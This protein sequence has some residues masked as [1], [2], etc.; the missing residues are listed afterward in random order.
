MESTSLVF[1]AVESQLSERQMCS[2]FLRGICREYKRLV[3]TIAYFMVIR[4]KTAARIGCRRQRW[5]SEAN[6]LEKRNKMKLFILQN[7]IAFH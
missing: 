4:M 3:V 7:N 1:T 2:R 5:R 6:L